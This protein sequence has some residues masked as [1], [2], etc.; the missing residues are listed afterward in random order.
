MLERRAAQLA[1]LNRMGTEISAALDVEQIQRIA[2]KFL[3]KNFGY[4]HVAMFIPDETRCILAMQERAGAFTNLFPKKHW[5]QFGSGMVGW[6]H[7]HHQT[8]LANDVTIDP[9]YVN[10][11]PDRI[12]TRSELAV[13]ILA[14]EKV[15]GILDIQSPLEN[16]F[17]QNDIVL[18]ETVANQLALAIVNG[19][20]YHQVSLR[21]EE[22]ERAEMLMRLQRDLLAGLSNQ[23]F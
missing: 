5:L 13:P 8:V 15:I 2:V 18:I 1:L 4:Y 3:H 16:A 7:Q 14:G 11:Y 9:R 21:L 19:G 22:Q 23:G 20:L 17:D 6:A 10:L 12:P